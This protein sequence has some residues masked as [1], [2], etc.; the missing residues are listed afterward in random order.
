MHEETNLAAEL[1]DAGFTRNEQKRGLLKWFIGFSMALNV[2]LIGA[3]IN[4]NKAEQVRTEKQQIILHEII[5]MQYKT[6]Q[7]VDTVIQKF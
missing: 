1:V 4:A 3:L 5:K 6:Q 2:F 7:R